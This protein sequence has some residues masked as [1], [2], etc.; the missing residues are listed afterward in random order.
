M[1]EKCTATQDPCDTDL[2]S[3]LISA[4]K[5]HAASIRRSLWVKENKRLYGSRGII[6]TDDAKKRRGGDGDAPPIID[7]PI[8]SPL[9]WR[10]WQGRVQ[11]KVDQVT[12]GKK[13]TFSRRQS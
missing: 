5:A 2:Q 1:A 7:G 8:Y 13:K 12:V 9:Y 10:A 4:A 6:A 11:T 3:V